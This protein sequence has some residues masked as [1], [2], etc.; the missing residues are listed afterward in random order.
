MPKALSPSKHTEI[1][2]H[3]HSGKT[4]LQVKNA[5]GVSIGAISKIRS[6]NCSSLFKSKGGRPSL[7]STT[8]INYAIHSITSGKHD[9]STQVTNDLINITGKPCS[10]KTVHCALFQAG[11]K[12]VVKTKRPLL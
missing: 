9:N 4:L 10:T 3:L 6:E 1:L 7:L 12:T 2:Q 8:N 11:L 5:T